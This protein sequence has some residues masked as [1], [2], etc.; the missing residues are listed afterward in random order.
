MTKAFCLYP[1]LY[2]SV[3][4]CVNLWALFASS[5]FPPSI[6]FEICAG[7]LAMANR[8]KINFPTSWSDASSDNPQGPPTYIR[9]TSENPG[10]LQVSFAS[11]TGAAPPPHMTDEDLIQLA[12]NLAMSPN[13]KE[14][15]KSNGNS[16]W[17]RFGCVVSTSP[18]FRMKVWV[19]N[20]GTET[21][22]VTHTGPNPPDEAELSE[23]DQIVM[24]IYI[25]DG[26]KPS[27]KKPSLWQRLR[28]GG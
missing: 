22:L 12:S 26:D 16:N 15:S 13:A 27:M 1:Y 7:H 4:I 10:A 28:G 20:K 9:H 23:A 6:C 18:E 5:E 14:I 8:L 25:A 3:F 24:G 19:I 21:V 11:Y 17:G 2:L